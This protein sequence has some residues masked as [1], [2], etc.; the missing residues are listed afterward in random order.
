[1][2]NII[3]KLINK[4]EPFSIEPSTDGETRLIIPLLGESR[5]MEIIEDGSYKIVIPSLRLFTLPKE[6]NFET[7][8]E[9]MKYLF[10]EDTQ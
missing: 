5:E 3:N 6:M 10:K 1:M 2:E 7:E 4:E 9:V 8:E